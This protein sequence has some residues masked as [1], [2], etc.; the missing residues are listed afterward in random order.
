MADLTL[1]SVKGTPLTHNEV[2]GNF[3]ALNDD[4]A[5]LNA[6]GWKDMLAPL[7][8]AGVPNQNAPVLRDF[9]VGTVLRREYDF[10]IGDYLFMQPF[11]VNHDVKPGG[12]AF[13]H[14]HW[15]TDGTS[16]AVVRWEFQILR[17]LG[18]NQEAFTQ[19]ATRF[20][21]QAGSGV[22]Y[23]H[24]VT[25]VAEADAMILTEPDEL[26]LVTV[27]RVTNGG[28]DNPDAV[29]G[30]MCD[31]HYESDRDTTPQKAPDFY[32]P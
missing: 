13:L 11:H 18:H 20:A 12:L 19:E 21:E 7:S 8:T 17:A 27:R 15:T 24:M 32:T 2:D 30:L 31:L 4:I 16:T 23:Q 9:S 25:E 3:V 6:T 1:R 14:M 5:A 29:F 10:A 28:T 26:I 22:A